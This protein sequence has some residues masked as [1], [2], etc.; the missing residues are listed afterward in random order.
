M[1]RK[2]LFVPLFILPSLVAC[3][4]STPTPEFHFDDR[5]LGVWYINTSFTGAMAINTKLEVKEDTLLI[6]KNDTQ[7]NTLNLMGYYAGYEGAYEYKL[8]YNQFIISYGEDETID[9]G[10]SYKYKEDEYNDMGEGSREKLSPIDYE[11]EDFPMEMINNYLNTTGNITPI[12]S[13]YYYLD[14]FMSSVYS[15]KCAEIMVKGA[16]TDR[17]KTYLDTL[18]SEG[19]T[20]KNYSGEVISN[21]VYV[22]YDKNQIYSYRF[23]NNPVDNEIDLFIY[24]YNSNI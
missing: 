15:A 20:F 6:Y 12:I 18:I 13:D 16:G 4:N 10:F 22:G 1:K 24:K 11:G 21:E 7:Y 19:A 5:L 9:W 23:W 14:L 17:L 2:L 8:G 3:N